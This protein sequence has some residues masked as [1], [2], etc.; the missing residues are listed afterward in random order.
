MKN[1]RKENEKKEILNRYRA[2]LRSCNE[3]TTKEDKKEIRKAFNLAVKGHENTRRKSGEPYSMVYDWNAWDSL[4]G[5]GVHYGSNDSVYVPT[6]VSDSNVAFSSDAVAS[7]VM[8]EVNSSC[9]AGYKGS[10]M[11]RNA[12]MLMTRCPNINTTEKA[13]SS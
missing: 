3:K 7:A 4:T 13:F 11:P 9:M 10:I 2:L 6:D 1:S 8:D 5:N 12:W